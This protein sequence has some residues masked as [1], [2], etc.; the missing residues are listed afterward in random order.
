VTA[1]TGTSWRRKAWRAGGLATALTLTVSMAGGVGSVAPAAAQ[2]PDGSGLFAPLDPED[3]VNQA[4]TTWDDYVP[5]P[6]KPAEW[7]DGSIKGS[8]QDF[9]AAVVLVDYEDQPFLITQPTG[10]HIVD[11]IVVGAVGDQSQQPILEERRTAEAIS[12][13]VHHVLQ[14]EF[15]VASTG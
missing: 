3:W 10:S 14:G 12:Q 13:L 4:D 9:K 15:H 8:V 5:V 11:G 1:T 2:G 6:G 7:A